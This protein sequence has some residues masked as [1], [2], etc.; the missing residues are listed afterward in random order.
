MGESLG[1]ELRE[2]RLDRLETSLASL[3]LSLPPASAMAEDEEE[4]SKPESPSPRPEEEDEEVEDPSREEEFACPEDDD[5][6]TTPTA[7][8]ANTTMAAAWYSSSS[9]DAAAPCL[10][11][12]DRNTVDSGSYLYMTIYLYVISCPALLFQAPW[13]HIKHVQGF[14]IAFPGGTRRWTPGVRRMGH[15]LI[16]L[17]LLGFNR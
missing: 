10:K 17:M 11:V 13:V 16:F 7:A 4:P 8:A 3:S 12:E 15:H 2:E 9:S 14:R 6:S 5:E 1:S